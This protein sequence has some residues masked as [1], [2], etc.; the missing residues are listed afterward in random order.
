MIGRVTIRNFKRFR[1]QTFE[2]TDSV[3]LAGPSVTERDQLRG[4]LTARESTR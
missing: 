4:A 3:V 2:L 1:E